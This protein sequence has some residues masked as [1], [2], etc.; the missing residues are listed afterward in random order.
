MINHVTIV[1]RLT[2]D[3]IIRVVPQSQDSV[4]SLSVALDRGKDKDGKS[5]GADYINVSVFG[6]VAVMCEKALRKGSKIGIDGRL[7]SGMYEKDGRRVFTVEVVAST[8]EF[9]S[10]ATDQTPE[11]AEEISDGEQMGFIP[12]DDIPF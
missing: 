1:G 4:A 12:A 3:P 10:P 2:K 7:R 6:P 5:K 9:M 8:V 11:P